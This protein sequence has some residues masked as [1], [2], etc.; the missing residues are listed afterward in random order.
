MTSLSRQ[1]AENEPNQS[2]QSAQSSQSTQSTAEIEMAVPP[3]ETPSAHCPYCDRPFATEELCV[4]HLGDSHQ[5]EW[6]ET[7][8]EEHED[9]YKTESDALFIYHMK[10][11]IALVV[12]FFAFMYTYVFVWI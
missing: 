4:L 6:T 10:V 9:A 11:I 5:D 8:R 7:E 12:L 1:N 3:D 2:T